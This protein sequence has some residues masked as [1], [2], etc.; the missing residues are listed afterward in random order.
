MF[1]LIT[2]VKSND[3]KSKMACKTKTITLLLLILLLS[4]SEKKTIEFTNKD[5]EDK[6]TNFIDKSNVNYSSENYV[7]VYIIEK[8]NKTSLKF[9]ST[10]PFECAFFQNSIDYNGKTVLFYSNLSSEKTNT[11]YKI[12]GT[13]KINCEDIVDKREIDLPYQ[14]SYEIKNGKIFRLDEIE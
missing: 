1:P 2:N 7:L 11:V 12:H 13:S 3:K 5:F 6:L 10:P 8:N 4:C 9:Y 14:M